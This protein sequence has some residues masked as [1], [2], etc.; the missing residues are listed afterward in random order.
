MK[1]S[2]RALGLALACALVC[3]ALGARLVPLLGIGHDE[4]FHAIVT[5]PLVYPDSH[6]PLSYFEFMPLMRDSYQGS[7]KIFWLALPFKLLGSSAASLRWATLLQACAAAF[8]LVLLTS[9]LYGLFIAA[10]V[11]LYVASDPALVLAGVYESAPMTLMLFWKFLGLYFL[12]EWWCFGGAPARCLLGAG[13]CFGQALWDKSHF[14]WVLA[15]LPVAALLALP[16]EKLKDK[17]TPRALL[18]LCLGFVLGGGP[19]LAHNLLHPLASIRNP[20]NGGWPLFLHLQELGQWLGT[21]WLILEATLTGGGQ[22]G[23]VPT[24]PPASLRACLWAV[25]AGSALLLPLGLRREPKTAL[26]HYGFWMGLAALI[27][28]AAWISPV[29]V[30]WHHLYTVYPLPHLAV[31]ALLWH[32]LRAYPEL[33]RA[34]FTVVVPAA[35]LLMANNVRLLR[36][37]EADARR[38]GGSLQ[39][40]E[41]IDE[42]S[43]W[44]DDFSRKNPGLPLLMDDGLE[45]RIEVLTQGRLRTGGLPISGEGFPL[46]FEQVEPLVSKDV[47]TQAAVILNLPVEGDRSVYTALPAFK[48][49]EFPLQELKTF[50]RKD[51]TPWA[52]A[53]L[54]RNP[55]M[56]ALSSAVDAAAKGDLAAAKKSLAAAQKSRLRL[57]ERV[58]VLKSGRV[59][60]PPVLPDLLALA[61]PY[62]N[63]LTPARR[64]AFAREAAKF[65]AGDAAP[66]LAAWIEGR[67]PDKKPERP[68][69]PLE[70]LLVAAHA[71]ANAG[72]AQ[73]AAAALEK[74]AALAPTSGQRRMMA[75]DWQAVGRYDKAL[76]ILTALAA[77]NPKDGAALHDQAV[78]EFLAGQKEKAVADLEAAITLSPGH[79]PAYLSL[80]AVH[81]KSGNLAAARAAY[82]RGLAAKTTPAFEPLRG[83]LKR[84]RG[85]L[86]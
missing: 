26:R 55:V 43:A 59:G 37:F 47:W 8:A 72:R 6:R 85:T 9:R 61:F 25:A 74:A 82:D 1:I 13:L 31:A 17:I 20:A 30:K 46:T 67:A 70:I 79:L 76:P 56:E 33:A 29:P 65:T 81:A 21:R 14:L 32:C 2:R 42:V 83:E 86:K 28:G 58:A 66:E 57:T 36:R 38:T 77:E 5:L 7:F 27:F 45:N 40:N 68:P 10:L 16:R 50:V 4:V 51:G 34:K 12:A 80:G 62:R 84:L 53:C 64:E 41:E 54:A 78:C 49:I 19:Y 48:L 23:I 3:A 22:W 69:T 73:E 63:R 39:F 44:S 75:G 15:A 11:G 52:R 35:L 60:P 24:S 71:A 18:W